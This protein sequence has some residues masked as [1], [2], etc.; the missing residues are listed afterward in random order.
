MHERNLTMLKTIDIVKKEELPVTGRQS[1]NGTIDCQAVDNSG[2]CQ[3]A[4]TE[5]VTGAFVTDSCHQMI[6]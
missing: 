2:L 5:F 4:R 1:S 3:I 6:E